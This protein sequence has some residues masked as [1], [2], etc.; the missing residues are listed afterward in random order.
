MGLRDKGLA[1]I[2]GRRRKEEQTKERG[3]TRR[4]NIKWE[5]IF[6]S[7]CFKENNNKTKQSKR[8]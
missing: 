7:F 1:K 4:K 6:F 5:G 8:E 3:K 2:R